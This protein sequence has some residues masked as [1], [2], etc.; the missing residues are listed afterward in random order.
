MQIIFM[1]VVGALFV[2]AVRREDGIAMFL[3]GM[4]FVTAGLLL[5]KLGGLI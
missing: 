1:L 2:D 4:V 3:S 5:M